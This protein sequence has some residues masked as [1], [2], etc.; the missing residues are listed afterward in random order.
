MRKA[1]LLAG[2]ALAAAAMTALP[3]AA[4]EVLFSGDG[5]F[6]P[7][8]STLGVVEIPGD[9][10]SFS[11]DLPA[12]IASN[13]TTQVTN[14]HYFVDG[15]EVTTEPLTSVTFYPASLGG[16]VDLNFDPGDTVSL[17]TSDANGFADLGSNLTITP[18]HYTFVLDG[19]S[20]AGEGELTVSSAPEPAAWAL[21][22]SGF[23]LAGA[24]LRRRRAA[25]A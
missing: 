23:G 13:P 19:S 10:F 12:V 18:G 6:G 22:I 15:T 20:Y 21:M 16:G 9:S 2:A 24:A 7:T 8:I 3:A 4:G 17:Y 5:L 11:F 25:I 1:I 14:S